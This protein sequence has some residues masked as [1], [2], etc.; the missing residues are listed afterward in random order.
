MFAHTERQ[1]APLRD[2]S[3]HVHVNSPLCEYRS[4]KAKRELTGGVRSTSM[5]EFHADLHISGCCCS[6][7]G[8][9]VS[10]AAS[11]GGALSE[12]FLHLRWTLRRFWHRALLAR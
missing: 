9:S 6:S 5:G 1:M 10:D 8:I 3:G 12:S 11:A 7:A 2:A 4:K